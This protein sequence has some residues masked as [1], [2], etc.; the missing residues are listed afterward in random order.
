MNKK[1]ITWI[2]AFVVMCLIFTFSAKT[3]NESSRTSAK[4]AAVILEL[5][6]FQTDS[7][8][9]QEY[10]SLFAMTQ[11]IVRK[12]AHAC[13]YAVLAVCI[14]FHLF[15]CEWRIKNIIFYS[16]VISFLYA[17][18]DEIHQLFVSG[19]SGQFKDVCIDMLGAI[20]GTFC[21]IFLI[22]IKQKLSSKNN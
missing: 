18:S 16:I 6:V 4:I 3:G 10:D 19:R 12:T 8:S 14:G 22:M 9:Q 21:F 17:G 5:P 15:I 11:H 1:Y 7:M 20:A 13:E 2:P